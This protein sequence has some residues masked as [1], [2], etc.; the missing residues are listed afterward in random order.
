[1]RPSAKALEKASSRTREAADIASSKPSW[2]DYVSEG[3]VSHAPEP[4]QDG[5]QDAQV[6]GHDAVVR[7]L[8]MNREHYMKQAQYSERHYA[9]KPRV[10]IR[11]RGGEKKQVLEHMAERSER[12]HWRP[13]T[14]IVVSDLAPGWVW[15]CE[16]GHRFGFE[17]GRRP[18]MTDCPEC[19]SEAIAEPCRG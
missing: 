11:G 14:G 8:E 5:Y 18:S 7:M 13:R 19:G 9:E 3:V 4:G 1:M 2:D 17:R 16:Q 12:K 10:E 6:H 15:R